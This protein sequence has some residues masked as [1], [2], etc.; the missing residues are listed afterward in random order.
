MRRSSVLPT[1]FFHPVT[2]TSGYTTSDL[3]DSYIGI[4]RPD[5]LTRLRSAFEL[6]VIYLPLTVP[7][8]AALEQEL[9]H[10][11]A[12]GHQ[13]EHDD[14][15]F[16]LALAS[17]YVVQ[18]RKEVLMPNRQPKIH[19]PGVFGHWQI[20]PLAALLSQAD[21]VRLSVTS[22]LVNA[23]VLVR[24]PQTRHPWTRNPRSARL[25][26]D[27]KLGRV[28]ISSSVSFCTPRATAQLNRPIAGFRPSKPRE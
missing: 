24:D 10:L 5:L 17:W 13:R 1:G 21:E 20:R 25:L 28:C 2:L 26:R 15:V 8:F 6:K 23:S 11:R 16:A 3:K 7:G 27:K 4:L 12:D 18:K 19:T 14:L 22:R 9:I